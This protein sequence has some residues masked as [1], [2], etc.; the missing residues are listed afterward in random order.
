MLMLTQHMALVAIAEALLVSYGNQ[1]LCSHGFIN[2]ALF[3]FI[4][5]DTLATKILWLLLILRLRMFQKFL[6]SIRNRRCVSLVG[7]I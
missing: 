1:E 7:Q 4:Q 6:S 5:C 3:K 2:T